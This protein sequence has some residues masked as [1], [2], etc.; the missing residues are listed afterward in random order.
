[1]VTSLDFITP[2]VC[3]QR[4][5]GVIYFDLS[6]AFDL[7]PHSLI[8]LMLNAFGLSGGCVNWF[9]SDLSNR[10]SQVRVSG[11]LPSSFEVV[12]DVPEESVLGPLLF[13]VFNN[14]LCGALAHSK[15]LHFADDIKI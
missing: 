12:S 7:I 6:S 5:A 8:L 15:Y 14:D 11:I 4:Q 9:C 3:Y 1:L 2:L 10:K 13:N